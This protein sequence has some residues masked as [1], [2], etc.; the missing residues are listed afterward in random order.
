MYGKKFP[1][2]VLILAA[3][4]TGIFLS[5]L[6]FN[7]SNHD[8]AVSATTPLLITAE[9]IYGD[10]LMTGVKRAETI[11]HISPSQELNIDVLYDAMAVSFLAINRGENPIN[12]NVTH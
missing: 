4:G 8:R 5:V 9:P 11:V 12:L 6:T 2:M 3:A 1:F 7:P 10:E